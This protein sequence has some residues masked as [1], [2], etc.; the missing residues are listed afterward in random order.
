MGGFPFCSFSL[1]H[2]LVLFLHRFFARIRMRTGT[3]SS[4]RDDKDEDEDRKSMNWEI[5]KGGTQKGL[6]EESGI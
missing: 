4:R 5:Q 2:P 6:R 3:T 1:S